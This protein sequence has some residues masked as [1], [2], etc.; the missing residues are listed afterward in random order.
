[1]KMNIL[2]TVNDRYVR[3]LLVMM[4]SLFQHQD[5]N[6]IRIYLMYSDVCSKNREKL[7]EK[8]ETH[9]AGFTEMFIEKDL[10]R[11]YPAFRYFSQEM[12]YRLLCGKYLPEKEQRVLYLDPDILVE[13]SLAELYQTDLEGKSIGAV[14]DYA[15]NHMLVSCK[16]RIGLPE[17]VPYVNSGVI[18][19]DLDRMRRLFSAE[20]M[21][22]ILEE[23]REVL[24]FPDQD[25]I[26][27]YFQGDIHYMDRG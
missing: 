2:V 6:R 1:M 4:D 19:F 21:F 5:G 3:P 18:L 10:F 14:E 26:N 20:R 22:S 16:K 17:N 12:Y 23:K 24:S 13:N 15:V 11:E 25:L 9:G 27:L 7:R 8:A